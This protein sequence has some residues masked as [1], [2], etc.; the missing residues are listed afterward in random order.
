[1][2]TSR[3]GARRSVDRREGIVDV[4]HCNNSARPT[5]RHGNAVVTVED[6]GVGIPLGMEDR[7]FDRFERAAGNE[8]Q[9]S[10]LGLA[11]V[12]AVAESHGGTVALELSCAPRG[13][14]W[15]TTIDLADA[16]VNSQHI[17]GASPMF[18][19]SGLA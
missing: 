4:A 11:I 12:R 18:R 10:G 13:A 14:P 19:R 1:M 7:V 9:G 3:E 15:N 6:D 17:E 5:T 8:T 2:P 16:R